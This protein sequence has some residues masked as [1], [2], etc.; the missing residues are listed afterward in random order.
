M[1]RKAKKKNVQMY[2]TLTLLE[3]VDRD[4]DDNVQNPSDEIIDFAKECVDMNEK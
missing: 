4:Q 1:S 3:G 2:K